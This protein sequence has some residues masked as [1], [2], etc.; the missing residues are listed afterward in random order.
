M[1]T[2]SSA[3]SRRAVA[4]VAA[5]AMIALCAVV[6]SSVGSSNAAGEETMLLSEGARKKLHEAVERAG[7]APSSKERTHI[8]HILMP[9]A[10]HLATRLLY[11]E[12]AEKARAN[13]TKPGHQA[14]EMVLSS[15]KEENSIEAMVK[16]K[17]VNINS[18]DWAQ[19]V[20]AKVP[21]KYHKLL[22]ALATQAAH[23]ATV[24]SFNKLKQQMLMA[25]KN[26][27]YMKHLPPTDPKA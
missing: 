21:A 14:M 16:N 12:V 18:G 7:K 13:P 6:Y 5:V 9:I 11:T 26:P 10:N 24:D 1:H 3:M 23:A 19:Q 15:H 20:Y 2:N 17:L 8:Q 22:P 4:A 25:E 27:S